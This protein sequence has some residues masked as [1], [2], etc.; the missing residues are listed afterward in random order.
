VAYEVLQALLLDAP[1]GPGT[2]ED[3]KEEEPGLCL[4]QLRSVQMSGLSFHHAPRDGELDFYTMLL[5]CIDLRRERGAGPVEVSIE[6]C[7][8]DLDEVQHLRR[9]AKVI[10]DGEEDGMNMIE[11]E[12]S[13][14][15]EDELGERDEGEDEEDEEETVAS[16]VLWI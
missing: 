8:V 6:R 5:R 15:G 12:C 16:D 9:V 7:T 3:G 1:G 11:D 2:V 14:E 13:E 10:W 4:P